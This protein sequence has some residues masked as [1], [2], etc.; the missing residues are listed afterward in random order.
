MPYLVAVTKVRRNH[1]FVSLN[2]GEIH[3]V[4]AQEILRNNPVAVDIVRAPIEDDILPL[5]K[6]IIGTSGRVYTEFPIP[7]GTSVSVSTIGYNMCVSFTNSPPAPTQSFFFH[8]RNPDLWGTDARQFRPERWLEMNGQVESPV[9]VYGNLYGHARSSDRALNTDLLFTQLYILRRCQEL[10][11]VAIRVGRSYF[12]H[13]RSPQ[14]AENLLLNSVIEM[15]AFLVTLIL[16]FDISHADHQPQ[17]KRTKSAMMTPIV[18]G[19]EHK[20]GQLPLKIAAIRYA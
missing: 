19:E 10:H 13:V 1:L 16:K 15:Q 6:P 8:D 2:G 18:L 11:W 7:K 14:E 17:I 3:S 12:H 9:G 4:L 20:G 5:S